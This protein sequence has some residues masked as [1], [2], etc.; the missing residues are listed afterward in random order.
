MSASYCKR[1]GQHVEFCDACEATVLDARIRLEQALRVRA[2]AA[3]ARAERYRD[4]LDR[5][6]RE[7]S[8]FGTQS[9]ARKALEEP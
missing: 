7:T 3:E 4:A 8:E 6:E 9:V 5:I 2:E 1:H